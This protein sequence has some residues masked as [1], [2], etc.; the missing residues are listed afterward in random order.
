MDFTLI[1]V[2]I[3]L[4]TGMIYGLDIVYFK[5]K[6]DGREP[7]LVIDYSRSFFPVLFLVLVGWCMAVGGL[8]D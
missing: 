5:G 1:L 4:A 7:G 3:V 8:V 6:R 2:A